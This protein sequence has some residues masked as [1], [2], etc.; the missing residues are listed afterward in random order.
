MSSAEAEYSTAAVACMN[1]SHLRMVMNELEGKPQDEFGTPP[2]KILL[3]SQAAIA[4]SKNF[5]DSKQTRHMDRRRHYVREGSN[6]GRHEL[7]YIP[8][9][10]ML[11]DP[12][13]KNCGKAE[14]QTR[15]KYMMANVPK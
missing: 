13:T 3:D 6:E 7:C 8:G 14:I 9:D 4:M 5:K 1:A 15:L 2:I 12:G 10:L 11:A